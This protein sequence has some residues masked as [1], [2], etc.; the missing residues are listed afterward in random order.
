M[1]RLA[2]RAGGHQ[3]EGA[4]HLAKRRFSAP[5]PLLAGPRKCG[6]SSPVTPTMGACSLWRAVALH[7]LLLLLG[8]CMAERQHGRSAL[9]PA[10]QLE[11]APAIDAAAELVGSAAPPQHPLLHMLRQRYGLDGSAIMHSSGSSISSGAAGSRS[12]DGSVTLQ[13]AEQGDS[14]RRRLSALLFRPKPPPS[15]PRPPLPPSPA[16]PPPVPPAPE[17]ACQMHQ[18]YV[19]A[20]VSSSDSGFKTFYGSSS[21]GT[22]LTPRDCC[23]AC[24]LT[25]G[26]VWWQWIEADSSTGAPNVNGN[27]C[28][29]YGALPADQTLQFWSPWVPSYTASPALSATTQPPTTPVPLTA[30]ARPLATSLSFAPATF[31]LSATAQPSASQPLAA[32][33]QPLAPAAQPVASPAHAFAAP[34]PLST[35]PRPFSLATQPLPSQPLA[36][37]AQPLTPAPSALATTTQPFATTTQPF[38][39]TIAL[40]AAARTLPAAAAVAAAPSP[41]DPGTFTTL[42]TAACSACESDRG[43]IGCAGM[44]GAPRVQPLNDY[45]LI[46]MVKKGLDEYMAKNQ[47]YA[48]CGNDYRLYASPLIKFSKACYQLVSGSQWFISVRIGYPCF[49]PPRRVGGKIVSYPAYG[50]WRVHNLFVNVYQQAPQHGITQPYVVYQVYRY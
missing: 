42:S 14:S 10:Q 30:T 26:C 12:Q 29:L 7:V 44:V 46:F 20:A 15:P 41:T 4:G 3:R 18:D 19:F 45:R 40:S 32:A 35:T 38:A 22:L 31:P 11:W 48:V 23:D 36:T 27:Q 13:P 16:P 37:T 8:A 47:V 21:Q 28:S 34:I 33:A 39:A 9:R 24:R 5:V 2:S 50:R 17:C 43:D 1:R 49:G 25:Y 6:R